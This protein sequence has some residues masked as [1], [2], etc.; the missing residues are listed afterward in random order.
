MSSCDRQQETQDLLQES[1]LEAASLIGE[2]VVHLC[3]LTP[4]RFT[5][6]VGSKRAKQR[7]NPFPSKQQS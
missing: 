4:P 6:S 7:F 2:Y 1:K 5:T 3:E